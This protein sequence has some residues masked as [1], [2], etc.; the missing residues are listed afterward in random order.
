[1]PQVVIE[2]WSQIWD[3]FSNADTGYQRAFTTNFEI[4]KSP[5]EIEIYIAIK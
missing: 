4:Y 1:M 2:T 5:T 3:Y